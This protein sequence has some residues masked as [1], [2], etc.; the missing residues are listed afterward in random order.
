[1]LNAVIEF[2]SSLPFLNNRKQILHAP[3][4]NLHFFIFPV[5]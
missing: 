5:S 4:D 2:S 3:T 1:M